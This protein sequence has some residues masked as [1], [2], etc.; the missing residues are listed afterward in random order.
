M[1]KRIDMNWNGAMGFE[2]DLDGHKLVVDALPVSGGDNLGPAP[3]ALMLVA[4]G[5]CT[6]MDVASIIT[7]PEVCVG[8]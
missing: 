3:K 2:T 6:G 4:L 1:K 7:Y 5:G 8:L